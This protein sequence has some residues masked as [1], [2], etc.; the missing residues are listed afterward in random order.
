MCLL[1]RPY[2]LFFLKNNSLILHSCAVLESACSDYWNGTWMKMQVAI[3]VPV[4]C[5]VH[6]T[7][8]TVLTP[9]RLSG[10]LPLTDHLQSRV[11]YV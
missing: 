8:D 10:L 9:S 2:I 4:S 1:H 7:R 6:A 3:D 5:R 11:G